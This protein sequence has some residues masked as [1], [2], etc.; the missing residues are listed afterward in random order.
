MQREIEEQAELLERNSET[1]AQNLKSIFSGRAFEMVLFAARG[2]SD[3]AALYGR[4][5]AE[6]FLG[7]PVCLAAPSVITKYG[8]DPRYSSCLAVG[9]SQSEASDVGAVLRQARAQGQ[10]ALAITNS[11]GSP[12]TSIAH[13]T[14]LLDVGEERSIAATKTYSASLLALRALAL[15]LGA[16]LESLDG[17]LPNDQWLGT[18]R[19][20]ARDFAPELIER[21]NRICFRARIFLRVRPRAGPQAHGVRVDSRRMLLHCRLSAWSDGTCRSKNACRRLWRTTRRV[22]IHRMPDSNGSGVG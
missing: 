1:Y 14:L 20:L 10:F 15:A 9:I 11:P 8:G 5:L 18:S 17:W 16:N 21:G 6:I 3:N 22:G 13:E 4:Y 7:I 12:I 2:S 19:G